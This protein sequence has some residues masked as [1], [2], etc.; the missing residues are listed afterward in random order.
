MKVPDGPWRG[1][2]AT[3]AFAVAAA[4]AMTGRW[5]A[6]ETLGPDPGPPVYVAASCAPSNASTRTGGIPAHFTAVAVLDCRTQVHRTQGGDTFV[7]STRRGTGDVTSAQSAFRA[8]ARGHERPNG[9]C[10]VTS[11][12]YLFVDAAGRVVLTRAPLGT[13]GTHGAAAHALSALT[14]TQLPDVA[15]TRP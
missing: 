9:Q 1:T 15:V 6:T 3:T 5:F 12:E 4:A 13:C 7:V 11:D 14:W 2:L 10:P 8:R